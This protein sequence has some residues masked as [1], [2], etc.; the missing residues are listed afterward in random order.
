MAASA[1]SVLK[2]L[3]AEFGDRVRFVTMY[4]REAHPGERVSQ[5]K[6][7]EEKMRHA[8]AYAHRDEIPWPV[9]VDDLDGSVHRRL[10]RLPD[11][12]YVVDESGT[13]A[14]RTLWSN[15]RS[16][17]R[18][19]L[20]AVLAGRKPPTP[21]RNATVAPMLRGMGVMHEVL[22]AAGPSAERDMMMTA[23]PVYGLARVAAVFRPL[24]PLGRGVAAVVA[25]SVFLLLTR[26]GLTWLRRRTHGSAAA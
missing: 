13:V 3:Y 1:S 4:V 23:P 20:G 22:G 19:A 12:A 24:P 10:G 26:K 16:G 25:S 7:F 21:R 9:V 17:L 18:S 14:A 8:R 11:V 15:D 6:S 2:E 5:P